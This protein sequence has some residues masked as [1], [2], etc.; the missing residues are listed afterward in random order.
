MGSAWTLWRK[1]ES[2]DGFGGLAA[3]L[4]IR[5]RSGFGVAVCKLD[6]RFLDEK[7]DGE[8]EEQEEEEQE[9]QEE[10]E[11]EEEEEGQVRTWLSNGGLVGVGFGG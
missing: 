6:M 2:W 1:V 3:R 9:E 7:G 10:Q 4:S 5:M 11:E 8:E